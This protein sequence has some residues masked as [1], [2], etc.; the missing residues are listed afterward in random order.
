MNT[1]MMV[2]ITWFHI[3]PFDSSIFAKQTLNLW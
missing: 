3:N 2:F 1:N